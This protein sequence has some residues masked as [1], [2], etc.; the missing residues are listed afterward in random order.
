MAMGEELITTAE[1]IQI[2][3][4]SLITENAALRAEVARLTAAIDRAVEIDA[5]YA[6][7]SDGYREPWEETDAIWREEY[8]ARS[9][10]FLFPELSTHA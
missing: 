3:V 7:M 8:L 1:F 5:N 6:Y 10:R 9:R 2:R 4:Q